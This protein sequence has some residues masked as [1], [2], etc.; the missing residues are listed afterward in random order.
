MAPVTRG[1]NQA[2]RLAPKDENKR[3]PRR[4]SRA[5]VALYGLEKKRAPTG[6]EDDDE[7]LPE[8]DDASD[9]FEVEEKGQQVRLPD[10]KVA[11]RFFHSSKV[12]IHSSGA[13]FH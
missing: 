11:R 1:N 7:M 2:G 6:L 4:P 5:E 13:T 8:F 3:L 10:A 9:E 12:H